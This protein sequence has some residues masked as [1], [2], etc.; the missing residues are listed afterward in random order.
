[1][2]ESRCLFGMV[3]VKTRE[4]DPSMETWIKQ[5][6]LVLI[7]MV[8]TVSGC[9]EDQRQEYG[10]MTEL[11]TVRKQFEESG[12]PAAYMIGVNLKTSKQISL[13]Y[14]YSENGDDIFR[15]ASMT[16]LITAVAALQLVEQGK[17]DLDESLHEWLPE[18]F[19]IPILGNDGQTYRS[20]KPISLRQLL[21]HTAGFGYGFS[22]QA[23]DHYLNQPDSDSNLDEV[24]TWVR[25]A[26]PGATYCYG[27]NMDWVGRLVEK[28]SGQSLEQYFRDH[29]TGPLG[30]DSTWFNPPETLYDRIVAYRVRKADQF[31]LEEPRVPQRTT[32]YSGGGGLLSS[33][34]D[35]L[36]LLTCL[37]R[38]GE[39]DGTRILKE[40]TVKTMFQDHLP[41]HLSP[42]FMDA[43][44]DHPLVTDGG[45]DRDLRNDRWGLS[46]ALEGENP[47][48]LRSEGTAYWAGV[49]NS[50][51][52]L[53]RKQG[54]V[55][56]Y[57]SQFLP[58]SDPD[59][60]GLYR[61]FEREVY[62]QTK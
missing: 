52:T 38:G 58:F 49:F 40:T 48:G 15:I 62:L 29:V 54:V 20:D 7:G 36:K 5:N 12:L 23:L 11:D 55:V 53:D 46:W 59:A 16:K 9:A 8:F 2:K 61:A 31:E 3:S 60:Y 6:V 19:N 26:E 28:V 37:Y 39:F 13:S 17:V 10:Q 35:Y 57:Y 30:M 45:F 33:A 4:F 56:I 51:F 42:G 50:Y 34:E 22:S 41:K 44:A 27:T 24:L 18:M 1:M 43:P 32:F 25:V 14:G 21:T 47:D